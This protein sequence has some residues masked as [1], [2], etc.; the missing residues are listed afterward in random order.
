MQ[1]YKCG[2]CSLIFRATQMCVKNKL[3]KFPVKES[4]IVYISTLTIQDISQHSRISIALQNYKA[5][6]RMM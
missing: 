5:M 1:N 4:K 3:K 2:T 6:H